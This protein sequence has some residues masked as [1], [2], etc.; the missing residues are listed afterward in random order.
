MILNQ[1]NATT[2]EIASLISKAVDDFIGLDYL[3]DDI[4]IMVA[5]RN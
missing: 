5:K 4:T 2:E 1:R 3:K